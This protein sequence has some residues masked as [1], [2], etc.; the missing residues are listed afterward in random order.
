[1]T[2]DGP[3]TRPPHLRPVTDEPPYD[4][5]Y[6]GIPAARRPPQDN[7]AEQAIL[8]ALLLRPAL[9]RELALELEPS[10]FYRPAHETI[11]NAIHHLA[12][13]LHGPADDNGEQL[14]G[15]VVLLGAH[16]ARTG[17][18]D[19]I[20]GP[21]YLTDLLAAV[22]IV[23]N[24]HHYAKIVRDTAR[25]RSLVEL[26]NRLTATGYKADP[27]ALDL[28]LGDAVELVD[29]VAMR[30]GPRTTHTG[31]GLK[32]LSWLLGGTPPVIPPPTYVRRDD[33]TALFY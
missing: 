24:V 25:A 3:P 22:P 2:H 28:A 12:D 7:A 33:G 31:A 13:Q 6:D 20:G 32:D 19:R 14:G 16:L 27:D 29:Q 23:E 10:D 21:T 8:G 18:L 26:G 9:A 15:D 5:E 4:P 30:F 11:W 17:D 1:M